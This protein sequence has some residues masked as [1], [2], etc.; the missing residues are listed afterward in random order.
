MENNG[1]MIIELI[2]EVDKKDQSA[3]KSEN[4]LDSEIG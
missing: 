2:P 1:C 3:L 4:R